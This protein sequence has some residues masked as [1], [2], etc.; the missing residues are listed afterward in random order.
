M[1]PKNSTD[2]QVFER[3]SSVCWGIL[4]ESLFL[5]VYATVVGLMGHK[6]KPY[7]KKFRGICKKNIWVKIQ[8]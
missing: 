5:L 6:I 7:L 2:F 8:I 4:I 1:Y 3:A